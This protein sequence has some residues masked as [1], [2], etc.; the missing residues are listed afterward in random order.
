MS[1]EDE[2]DEMQVRS[3]YPAFFAGASPSEAAVFMA[4][5][6]M[7][8]SLVLGVNTERD[9]LL[10]SEEAELEEQCVSAEASLMEILSYLKTLPAFVRLDRTEQDRI[11]RDFKAVFS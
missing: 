6:W 10:K 5:Y 1:Q 9:E 3:A 11:T 2:I 4:L 8:Q 7:H